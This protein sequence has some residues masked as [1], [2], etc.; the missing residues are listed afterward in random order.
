MPLVYPKESAKNIISSLKFSVGLWAHQKDAIERILTNSSKRFGFL[1][2]PG[3]G[4]TLTTIAMLRIISRATKQV[5]RTLII[6]PQGVRINWFR[7]IANEVSA[8]IASQVQVVDGTPL[9][10]KKQLTDKTKHIFIVSQDI[11]RTDSF[12]IILKHPWDVIIVDEFHNFKDPSAPT[13]WKRL[14]KILAAN[15]NCF[16]FALTGT[17]I[18]NTPL[19][20]Y[21]LLS[22]LGAVTDSYT[23]FKLRYF[24]D[25]NASFANK[26]WHFPKWTIR[27]GCVSEVN[28]LIDSC[29]ARALLDECVDLPPLIRQEILV[30]LS[31]EQSKLYRDI[32]KKFVGAV[33]GDSSKIIAPE[34][35]LTQSLRLQQIANGIATYD[36]WR[37]DGV[38][39]SATELIPCDKYNILEDQLR[40]ILGANE[41]NKVIIWSAWADTYGKLA[42]SCE[43]VG[44]FHTSITGRESATEKQEAK[45]RFES[46]PDCRICIANQAAG[47]EGIELTAANYM[48]YFAKTHALGKDIQSQA[49]A[50]R[51][52]SERHKSIVR[53]DLVSEGTIEEVITAALKDK[54]TMAELVLDMR[55]HYGFRPRTRDTGP[56]FT[57]TT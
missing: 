16:R 47:G 27:P 24:E 21:T 57:Q 19:D 25:A 49:R 9:S 13:R 11:F 20:A 55:R 56:E 39:Q 42:E 7:N 38:A 40:I 51:P 50:R 2:E 32:E 5:P 44:T 36:E 30:P 8:R 45:D 29:C 52:G 31:S 54:K 35:V 41:K 34:L 14:R 10:R 18:L 6:C 43:N 48:I 22:F 26:P 33:F 23:A 3:C 15:R 28:A 12:D 4:K 37:P 1:F 17:P 53:I 46:D